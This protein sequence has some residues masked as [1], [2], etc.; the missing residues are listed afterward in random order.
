VYLHFTPYKELLQARS[1]KKSFHAYKEDA[2]FKGRFDLT[3][4]QLTG[5]GKVDL[6]KQI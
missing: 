6:E 5:N 3:K 2:S 1:L 4:H